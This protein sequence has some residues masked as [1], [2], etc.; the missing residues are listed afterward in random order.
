MARD[1]EQS[2]V[3]AKG[4]KKSN[5]SELH[6]IQLAPF[7]FLLGTVLRVALVTFLLLVSMDFTACNDHGGGSQPIAP[8]LLFNGTGTS[9]NDVRAVETILNKGHVEYST[10]NSSQLNNMNKSQLRGY[11]L[12]IVPG[13]NFLK[14]G[15]SLTTNTTV[16]IR[17][18]VHNGL[19]YLGICAGALL[20]GN[21]PANGL[22]MTEGVHFP[23]YSV[24]NQG[25]HKAATPIVVMGGPTLEHYW[26]DGPELTGWGAIV[27][28]YP[29]GTPAIVE[30]NYGSG[31][32][33]LSGVHP[34][35]P[36]N[37]RRGMTFTTPA[38][39]DN[40]Y[41]W[42]LIDAAL[43]RVALPHF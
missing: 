43:N 31:W 37:W 39:A 3:F 24:V 33:I 6:F 26:E 4:A 21:S 13:G 14:M 30:G 16:N 32:V 40:D 11:R 10:V 12:L 8:V 22:N 28:K 29:N 38:S 41:A 1:D 19:N 23:F 7:R 17:N 34:E 27:G 42:T 25:I 20:A 18:A 2:T 9:P 36:S 15:N 5:Y 35:A